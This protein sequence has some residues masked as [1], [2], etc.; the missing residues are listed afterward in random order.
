MC[1]SKKSKKCTNNIFRLICSL[2]THAL[3]FDRKLNYLMRITQ[4][5][6]SKLPH[7]IYV[8]N[9]LFLSKFNINGHGNIL[10]IHK[11]VINIFVMILIKCDYTLFTNVF[12]SQLISY[13][14]SQTLRFEHIITF[15]N[16][17]VPQF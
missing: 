3:K 17:Y 5:S 2:L 11:V 12:I 8:I 9:N 7:I 14:A 4:T 1:T 15:F 16:F 6:I 13:N 10:W